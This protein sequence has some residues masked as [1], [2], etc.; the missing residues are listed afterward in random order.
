MRNAI[1]YGAKCW[2]L[3]MEDERRLKTIE[4]RMLRMNVRKPGKI[5]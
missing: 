1:A 4:M 2:A 5:K 3:K